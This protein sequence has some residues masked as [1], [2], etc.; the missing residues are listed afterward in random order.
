MVLELSKNHLAGK[1]CIL[2]L[3]AVTVQGLPRHP[4]N[5]SVHVGGGTLLPTGPCMQGRKQYNRR[6][7]A[8]LTVLGCSQTTVQVRTAC[9]V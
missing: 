2:M 3:E 6:K 5:A 1:F 8:Y 4:F 9:W 7:L